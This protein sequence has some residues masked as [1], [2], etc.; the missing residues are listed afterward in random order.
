MK[1]VD[2][3]IPLPRA[4]GLGVTLDEEAASKAAGEDLGFFDGEGGG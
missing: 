2:G 4:P 3:P 1:I